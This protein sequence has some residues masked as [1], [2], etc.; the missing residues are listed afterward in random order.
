[1]VT[2]VKDGELAR[3]SCFGSSNCCIPSPCVL[4]NA[5]AEYL[6]SWKLH[7]FQH[8]FDEPHCLSKW[9]W[10]AGT[11]DGS[12]DFH[13]MESLERDGRAPG[14]SE[15]KPGRHILDPG[16]GGAGKP[17]GFLAGDCSWM[18]SG[19]YGK[20]GKS[21]DSFLGNFRSWQFDNVLDF[22]DPRDSMCCEGS[23]VTKGGKWWLNMNKMLPCRHICRLNADFRNPNFWWKKLRLADILIWSRATLKICMSHCGPEVV[24]CAAGSHSF[25]V[26]PRQGVKLPNHLPGVLRYTNNCNNVFLVRPL[27]QIPVAVG[28]TFAIAM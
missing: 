21:K 2:D 3:G 15:T 5:Q 7:V 28:H 25:G 8:S 26:A 22:R 16:A 12:T 17:N 20:M 13:S 6:E 18:F 23:K 14:W 9:C 1:M 10:E 19:K 11:T 24:L 4:G 27:G